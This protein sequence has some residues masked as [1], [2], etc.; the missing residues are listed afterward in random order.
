MRCLFEHFAFEHLSSVFTKPTHCRRVCFSGA[1]TVAG[2]AEPIQKLLGLVPVIAVS[3]NSF[4][5]Y[6][7][8]PFGV[9]RSPVGSPKSLKVSF[10]IVAYLRPNL[11]P[12]AI[13]LR[14][15]GF[16]VSRGRGPAD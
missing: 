3:P 6:R 14:F 1:P 8:S 11:R 7:L 5:F 13:R 2:G 16:F 4:F 9:F 10:T 12:L 15:A